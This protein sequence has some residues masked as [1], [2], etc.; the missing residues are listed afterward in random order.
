MPARVRNTFPTPEGSSFRTS[1]LEQARVLFVSFVQGLF[2]AAPTGEFHWD[3]DPQKSE[4]IIRD[5]NPIHVDTIGKR[6]AINFSIGPVQFYHLGMDDLLSYRFDI[7]RKDKGVLIPGTMSINVCS[8]VDLEAHNLA[9]VVAEHIWLLR[10]LF[11][12]RGFFELGRGIQ[13]TPPSPPGTIVQGDAADEWYC[14]TISV[15]WQFSRTSSLTP[16]GQ[17][18]LGNMEVALKVNAAQKVESL[19]WPSSGS[20]EL[21]LI[22]AECL[23]PSFAPD[24]SDAHGATP[25]PSG[26]KHNPLPLQPHPLN[27]AKLVTVRVVRPHRASSKNPHGVR[28]STLPIDMRCKGE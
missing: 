9:W 27:P 6:P 21:P 28:A 13:I 20:A 1:P 11:L 10:D 22:T 8:R 12:K 14:S 4:I 3:S 5:E 2:A 17:T 18:V 19:G 15:P 25:D 7:A 26:I 24:A 23:P 16:L